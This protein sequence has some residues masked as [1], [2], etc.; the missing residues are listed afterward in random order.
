MT[1][2]AATLEITRGMNYSETGGSLF[3]ALLLSDGVAAASTGAV[4]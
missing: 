1:Q 2:K 4:I 3:E